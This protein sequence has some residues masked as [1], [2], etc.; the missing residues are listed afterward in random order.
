MDFQKYV[1]VCGASDECL[2]AEDWVRE[3]GFVRG[4]WIGFVR[5]GS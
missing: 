3:G 1:D 5:V 4:S 2:L